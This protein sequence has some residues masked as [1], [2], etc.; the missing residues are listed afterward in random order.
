MLRRFRGCAD[1]ATGWGQLCGGYLYNTI[2]GLPTGKRQQ[3]KPDI[4]NDTKVM[5]TALAHEANQPLASIAIA[6]A[7]GQQRADEE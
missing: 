7:L 2:S 3:A 5:K 1:A 6:L 4:F